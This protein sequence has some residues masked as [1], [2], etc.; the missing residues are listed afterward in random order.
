MAAVFLLIQIPS[1]SSL[2]SSSSSSLSL[3]LSSSSSYKLRV[4]TLL[5]ARRNS[6]CALPSNARLGTR[7][8][9]RPRPCTECMP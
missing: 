2:S 8:C 1:S 4:A 3:S 5:I 7:G 6:V 9:N